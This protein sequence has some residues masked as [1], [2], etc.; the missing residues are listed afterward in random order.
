MFE[1][2]F[3]PM[4]ERYERV[5]TARLLF[6]GVLFGGSLILSILVCIGLI[7]TFPD[8]RWY[9]ILGIFILWLIKVAC[10]YGYM[11][12]VIAEQQAQAAVEQQQLDKTL[13]LVT[14][15]ATLVMDLLHQF[16]KK[17]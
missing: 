15:T 12:I 16:K 7:L 6:Y 1:A 9:I 13:G 3:K 2:Y 11:R 5:F 14:S 8:F 17:R 10:F 4:L